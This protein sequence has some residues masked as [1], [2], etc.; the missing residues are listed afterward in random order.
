MSRPLRVMWLG[1]RGFPN[2]QGGV[3]THAE[4]LCPLLASL[5][6]ELTVIA[7]SRYQRPLGQE[8]WHG[9][10]FV[11]LWSPRSARL[12][13]LVHSLAGVAYAALKRPDIL[14][15]QG[16]GPS[17][18]VPLARLLGLRVVVTH[19]GHDYERQKWGRIAKAALRL[20]ERWGMAFA[21]QRIVITKTIQDAISVIYCKD[22]TVIPNGVNPADD[23]RAASDAPAALGLYPGRYA[24]LVGRLVPEKRHHDLINAFTAAALP[25]WKL[26]IVGGADHP[27]A[28]AC[29]VLDAPRTHPNVVCTGFMTGEPLKEMYAHAG[30][31]VLPSSHEGL[32]IVMLEAISHG[33]RVI[34]SDIPPNREVASEM[35]THYPLGDTDALAAC[36][37]KLASEYISEDSRAAGR[38]LIACQYAW[39]Q[40]A[41][42]T[43]HVYAR[44]LRDST[45]GHRHLDGNVQ[46]FQS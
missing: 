35:V 3:E 5:G 39:P 16:I 37:R 10:R 31:F 11:R 8:T 38:D 32:P 33:V 40:I 4:H 14:H 45:H 15:I 6:C 22:S 25:G 42:R 41:Q 26:A 24:L 13:A 34:A 17:L 30:V 27:D 18:A 21:N 23:T 44:A 1:L 20:G 29:S 28:Y 36:L 43:L 7:R 46:D 12:E 9:V 19:H 2:V